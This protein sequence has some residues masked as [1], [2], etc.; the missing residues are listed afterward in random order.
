MSHVTQPARWTGY[1][2]LAPR[3]S[4]RGRSSATRA[5]LFALPTTA[6]SYNAK[7]FPCKLCKTDYESEA[8]LEFH[9]QEH[10]NGKFVIN[11]P[12]PPV[13][14]E[15]KEDSQETT[16]LDMDEGS[17][18]GRRLRCNMCG[19]RFQ[20]RSLFGQHL[21]DHENPEGSRTARKKGGES[22]SAPTLV[23]MEKSQDD[24]DEKEKVM[25]E[26]PS[27]LR[28]QMGSPEEYFVEEEEEDDDDDEDDRDDEETYEC[29]ECHSTFSSYRGLLTHTSRKHGNA[30]MNALRNKA[31]KTENI[32]D[33]Y[34]ETYKYAEIG[35]VPG[36][37]S[38]KDTEVFPCRQ[39][40]DRIFLTSYGL[41]RHTRLTHPDKVK[42]VLQYIDDIERHKSMASNIGSVVDTPVIRAR[43][44]GRGRRGRGRSLTNTSSSRS[45]RYREDTPS[46]PIVLGDEYDEFSF[47]ALPPYNPDEDSQ[48]GKEEDT[49]YVYE[50]SVSEDDLVQSRHSST[51]RQR[52]SST[53]S[54]RDFQI[55]LDETGDMYQIVRQ[56][57]EAMVAAASFTE[58]RAHG[59][60]RRSNGTPKAKYQSCETCGILI[61]TEH[62]RAMESHMKAHQKNM[63]LRQELLRLY[64]NNWVDQVT[65]RE[66]NLV[67][68]DG[69]KL[70]Q[71]RRNVHVKRRHFL[72][73]FCGDVFRNMRDLN[74]HKERRHEAFEGHR[75][76]ADP[77]ASMTFS[78]QRRGNNYEDSRSFY[79]TDASRVSD[80]P[81]IMTCA[82]CKAMFGRVGEYMQHMLEI[83]HRLDSVTTLD[84]K[85]FAPFKV[86][87]YKGKVHFGCCD[88]ILYD[89]NEMAVHRRTVHGSSASG[90]PKKCRYCPIVLMN[91]A[92]YDRH[93]A[94]H[95]FR[96]CTICHCSFGT[97][98]ADY[99]LYRSHMLKHR[100]HGY[101]IPL[102]MI[103]DGINPTERDFLMAVNNEEECGDGSDDDYS[104]FSGSGVESN[105]E[106][107]EDDENLITCFFCG[108]YFSCVGRSRVHM[109]LHLQKH[110]RGMKFKTVPFSGKLNH[111][112]R[113]YLCGKV[114]YRRAA[115]AFHFIQCMRRR[116]GF[117]RT[118][119]DRPL[120]LVPKKEEEDILSSKL[121]PQSIP[122]PAITAGEALPMEL[123]DELDARGKENSGDSFKSPSFLNRSFLLTWKS[124]DDKADSVEISCMLCGET[125][126]NFLQAAFH[127]KKVHIDNGEDKLENVDRKL[128]EQNLENS[129]M[130]GMSTTKSNKKSESATSKIARVNNTT[131]VVFPIYGGLDRPENNK[132][133]RC[134]NC[135][136]NFQ[137]KQELER[138]K[139]SHRP[140]REYRCRICRQ[141]FW[142]SKGLDRHLKLH[143]VNNMYCQICFKKFKT[144]EALQ[145]H[146]TCHELAN[147]LYQCEDCNL[148]VCSMRQL[149]NHFMQSH[150][151]ISILTCMVCAA[152]HTD[153]RV[154]KQHI[155]A[156]HPDLV[157][158]CVKCKKQFNC[159]FL[160]KRHFNRLHMY[161]RTES[162]PS[163][164]KIFFDKRSLILH[165]WHHLSFAGRFQ[166]MICDQLFD[167]TRQMQVHL[168]SSHSEIVVKDE[169]DNGI[170][171][172]D[173]E[174]IRRGYVQRG[175]DSVEVEYMSQCCFCVKAFAN[176]VE[177]VNHLFLRHGF[178]RQPPKCYAC[179]ASFNF[180]KTLRAHLAA[181]HGIYSNSNNT[182]D[183][184]MAEIPNESVTG[185]SEHEESMLMGGMADV[186]YVN[187][188]S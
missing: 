7:R 188:F 92:T 84:A 73:R 96:K 95:R 111:K 174:K 114:R 43:G 132:K 169:G 130:F 18:R 27:L 35:D 5:R 77:N 103:D 108:K 178:A 165:R 138:H 60:P 159:P 74:L 140:K 122:T 167:N 156:A 47:P 53:Y 143:D 94:T 110:L 118:E 129:G 19:E 82:Y 102:S 162:C 119:I 171:V 33:D 176:K 139:L 6:S 144:C 137:T 24:V 55:E 91:T 93:I 125:F 166:C 105:A 97:S 181:R 26:P 25:S 52:R 115:M 8:E 121:I 88:L 57:S 1:A 163:C 145:K 46:P 98:T 87:C 68:K 172:Y 22:D 20:D 133:F 113:C 49:E 14:S 65:C 67:F 50:S 76:G 83:H 59:R 12:P 161:E 99:T 64:G 117:I 78:Y 38:T 44:R 40:P 72:C 37:A 183:V 10:E 179:G 128:F 61:N 58:S 51:G 175:G 29:K 36:A 136:M 90:R 149:N 23:K 116:R 141:H 146:E 142:T 34:S 173:T 11:I 187:T 4:A 31:L 157:V 185:I 155:R 120:L 123:Q 164:G 170:F 147:S 160:V 9:I 100:E 54:N 152:I 106:D 85:Y 89:H 177:A 150:C 107:D 124:V 16:N 151:G 101:D 134:F 2:V 135:L 39:C 126:E 15:L 32:Y 62:P 13:L 180:V 186:G 158:R 153:K 45:L 127:V 42:E 86:D 30:A 154:L 81:F 168:K 69:D 182:Q 56:H 109:K 112:L 71:H 184:E 21:A 131:A 66:C 63:E 104:V 41:E 17:F 3:G 48:G 75:R 79:G 70:E 80:L 28:E 148:S